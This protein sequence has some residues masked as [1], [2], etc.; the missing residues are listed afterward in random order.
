VRS[1]H[2][3]HG[4]EHQLVAVLHPH[5]V[6]V[7]QRR[8]RLLRLPTFSPAKLGDETRE[9]LRGGSCCRGDL[10]LDGAHALVPCGAGSREH[11]GRGTVCLLLFSGLLA[12]VRRLSKLWLG[13]ADEKRGS[14]VW[15]LCR[16]ERPVPGNLVGHVVSSSRLPCLLGALETSRSGPL[17]QAETTVN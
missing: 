2:A 7:P 8:P 5:L 11:S 12:I 10:T 13:R 1:Y 14:T 6:A 15:P 4:S 16:A 17:P 9:G 3:D